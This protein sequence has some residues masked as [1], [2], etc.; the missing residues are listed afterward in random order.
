MRLKL[1]TTTL[2]VFGLFLLVSWPWSVGRA[3]SREAPVEE[4]L[5]YAKRLAFFVSGTV[6]VFGATGI[7]ALLVARQARKELREEAMANLKELLE[8]TLQDHG[9]RGQ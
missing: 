3:P 1:A 6:V 8:G 4:R 2:L 9:R 7:L 5:A